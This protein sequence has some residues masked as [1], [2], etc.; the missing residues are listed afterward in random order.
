M[1]GVRNTMIAS[2]SGHQPLRGFGSTMKHIIQ[3]AVMAIAEI[4]YACDEIRAANLCRSD[5]TTIMVISVMNAMR[6]RGVT[7]NS[8][9][10]TVP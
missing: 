9:C 2:S 4:M 5:G 10:M 6:A 3:E 7:K 1:Q 8:V